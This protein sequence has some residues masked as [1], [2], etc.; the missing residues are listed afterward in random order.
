MIRH[1]GKARYQNII[2]GIAET[3]CFFNKL[4]GM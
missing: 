4:I 3:W 1:F 2:I